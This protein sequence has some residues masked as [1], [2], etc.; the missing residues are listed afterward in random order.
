MA[1]LKYIIFYITPLGFGKYWSFI[2]N[3]FTP[4]GLKHAV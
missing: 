3:H 2:Y 1:R 4:S